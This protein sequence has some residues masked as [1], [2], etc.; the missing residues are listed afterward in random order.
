MVGDRPFAAST[1]ATATAA[2]AAT[3]RA[4]EAEE[5]HDGGIED[6]MGIISRQLAGE[7]VK[8]AYGQKDKVGLS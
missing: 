2:T 5:T 7:E 8:E 1:V 4:K 3:L 6:L